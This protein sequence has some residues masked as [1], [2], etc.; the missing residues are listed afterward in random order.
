M[1]SDRPGTPAR[2]AHTP[3]TIRS[4]LTPAWLA[5]YSSSMICSSSSEFILAMMR[6][7]LPAWAARASARISSTMPSCMVKGDCI[8]DLSAARAQPGQLGEDLVHV[9]AQLGIGGQ[10]AEV[11]VQARGT[12][13][14]VA[15]AQVGVAAQPALSRRS[16]TAILACVLCATTP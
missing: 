10:Q 7:R 8:S 12:R 9:L 1:F 5:L 14:V 15:G 16:T 2:S 13:M 6:A 3:R 11:G 4:I